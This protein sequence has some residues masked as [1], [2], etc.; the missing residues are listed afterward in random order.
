[1][2][3]RQTSVA[4]CTYSHRPGL[5]LHLAQWD[6]EATA[7]TTRDATASCRKGQEDV[8]RPPQIFSLY[9]RCNHQT[10]NATREHD[11]TGSSHQPLGGGSGAAGATDRPL[12]RGDKEFIDYDMPDFFDNDHTTLHSTY[13]AAVAYPPLP[14][15]DMP[16]DRRLEVKARSL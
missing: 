11:H 16:G 2:G 8:G 3:G 7:E 10:A 15:T 4:R 6:G 13:Y 14:T 5:V 1:M 12:L 9:K